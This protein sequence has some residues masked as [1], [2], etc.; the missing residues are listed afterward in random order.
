[1][2]MQA[3]TFVP[4]MSQ[5]AGGSDEPLTQVSMDLVELSTAPVADAR[6]EVP[7]GYQTA[8]MEDLIKDAIGTIKPPPQGGPGPAAVRPAATIPEGAAVREGNGVSAPQILERRSLDAG[9]DQHAAEAVSRWKFKPGMKDGRPV[10][11]E[12]TIEVSFHLL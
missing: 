8:A 7:A 5:L 11:V 2:R 12:T 9:L 1:M 3:L 10:P 6:F 4:A